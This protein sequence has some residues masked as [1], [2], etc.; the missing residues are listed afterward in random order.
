M[1]ETVLLVEHLYKA[2]DS[3]KAVNDVS[4]EVKAG[5]IFGLLGP[6]GAGKT[7]TINMICSLL[8]GDS[9][10]VSINN[11]PINSQN[12]TL[13]KQ[14]GVVPQDIALYEELNAIDNLVFWGRLYG[15]SGPDLKNRT[16]ALLTKVGLLERA[17]EPVSRYSGGMKR[18][19]NLAIGLLHEPDLLLLDEPTVG[20]DPQARHQMLD[21]IRETAQRGTAILYTTH[22]MDEAEQLCDRLAIMDH[23]HILA[24]GSLSE[25]ETL[26]GE[27]RILQIG[28]SFMTDQI[29]KLLPTLSEIQLINRDQTQLTLSIPFS[30]AIG[31][32]LAVLQEHD[33]QVEH[34]DI[35]NPNLDSVF[36]KLTGREFKD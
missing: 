20:I 12:S 23:G 9:G 26:V 27:R 15:L 30:M 24:M 1:A 21:L 25:L 10:S 5:E 29:D 7:T 11:M 2:F 35:K 19:L 8:P 34:L 3:L 32:I 6:N 13:R 33:L 28:G 18:R 17:K 36:L 31:Q 4:F 14:M 22:Y 16:T